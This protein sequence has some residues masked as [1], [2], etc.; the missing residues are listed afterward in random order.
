[1]VEVLHPLVVHHAEHD[2]L[3]QFAHDARRELRLPRLVVVL[4]DFFQRLAEFVAAHGLQFFLFQRAL[5]RV[6]ALRVL[7]QAVQCPFFRIQFL[8]RVLVHLGLDDFPDHIHDALAKLLALQHLAALRVDDLTL[9]VHHIVVFEDVLSH[10]EIPRFH[11]LLRVLN[12]TGNQRMLDGLVLFHAQLVHDL[13]DALGREQAQE[14]VLQ[15]QVKAGRTGIALTARAAAQLVVD[16]PRLVPLRADDRKAAELRDALAQ[17]DVRAAPGHVRRN[18]DRAELAG[19]LDDFRFLL[20]VLGVQ[21]IV[22]NL[23]LFQKRGKLFRL[24]NRRGA[25]QNRASRRVQLVH[26]VGDGIVLRALR[27][28]NEVR[29]VHADDRL[30]CRHDHDRQLVNLEELVLLGLRRARHARKLFVHAEIILESN[31]RQR[32]GLA[33]NLHALLRLDGLMEAVRIAA[34]EHQPPGELVDDDDL[35]VPHHIIAVTVHDRLRAER[36]VEAMGILDIFRRIE[37]LHTENLLHLVDG[38]VAWR[39]GLLFLVHRVVLAL[40][41]R[42]HR[43]R[44]PRVY[45]GGFRPRPGNNQ[46]RPRLVDQDRVHLVHDGEMQITL[47]HLVG[48]NHHIVA[49][50][51]ETVLIVRAEG[52]ITA[53]RI[54]ARGEIEVVLD[55]SHR[56]PEELVKMPHP[57]AVTLGQILVD[58]DHMD[59]LACQ[60]V[61]IHGQRRHQRLAFARFHLGDLALVQAHAADELH[62]EMAH[63]QN[64]T[65]CLAANREGF[66][67]NIVQRLA[68]G[69]PLLEFIRMRSQRRIRQILQ[70]RFH[71]V[72][73]F[74]GLLHALDFFIVVVTQKA[75]QE[76]PQSRTT[77]QHLS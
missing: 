50:I 16:A 67:Q 61:Q 27:L 31:R 12:G 72:D 40:P 71:R 73:L 49:Q 28:V 14:V 18:G 51:I 68:L 69:E 33:L 22:R 20:M 25:N 26:R 54:F 64:T 43:L 1:M 75:L 55:E 19:V 65:R 21:H 23:V 56:Q 32:L 2:D 30:V 35:A 39:D 59:A 29:L 9:L 58:R 13:R 37:I 5:R 4:G 3:F 11:F 46:R 63:A 8:V 10:I 41:E 48:R 70:I 42:R 77:P 47:H 45:L 17:N 24:R 66:R 6:D 44:H 15:R 53:I 38:L 36:R 52:H 7:D 34:P 62:V 76:S 60:R 74:D 57:L